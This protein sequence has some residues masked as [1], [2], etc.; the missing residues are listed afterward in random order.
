MKSLPLFFK[1]FKYLR[2][3]WIREIMLLLLMVIT[4][5]CSLASPYILKIIIDKVFP[6]G[7]FQ[8]LINI[9]AILV[10][11]NIMRI[12]ISFWSDYLY[13]W[14]SNHIVLDLRKDLFD[15][16]IHLPMS[17]FDK[18]KTGDLIHRINNEV[19]S[20][21]NMITGS[22]VRFINNFFTILGLTIALCLL[23]WKL[24]AISMVVVPFVFINTRYFQPKIHKIIKKA[25]E[26]DSD[27][28]N[29]FVERF[30]N[31]KLI[32]SY[33]RYNY[34]NHKLVSN[35]KELIGFNIINTKLS[36]G[37]SSIST[38]LVTLSPILIFVWGGKEVMLGAM[39]LG[40]LVAF[41][42]YL[43][44][45][46][47]PMRDIMSLYWDLVR[48]SVSMQRIF[49]FME[50]PVEEVS[51]EQLK[52]KSGKGNLYSVIGNRY[53]VGN[54][55]MESWEQKSKAKSHRLIADSSFKIGKCIRFEN[56]H[57][58]Y[59]DHWILNDLNLEFEKGKKYA[60]VGSSGCGK[61]TI[62]NL[63]NRFYEPQEGKILVDNNLVQ[64]FNLH[65]LRRRIAL[66]TQDN[67]L[68]HESIWENI[69]YGDF[70]SSDEQITDAAKLTNIYDHATSLKEGFSSKIG[71]K[72]TKI[73]GG[74]KQRIAIA[75]AML[76]R[77]ELI[78]LD[79]ATSALD[80]ESE[81]Q[82][83]L[84]LSNMYKDKT[85]IMISHRLS[86]IKDVDEIIYMDKGQVVEQGSYSELTGKK[87]LFWKLFKGQ[88]E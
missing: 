3:Y 73:S 45:L 35:I 7:D 10:G 20:I 24:F 64:S 42:Q 70:E 9:L 12:T 27:I 47:N 80:S 82:I 46:F 28:L 29:Y 13:V 16:L 65:E 44:R 14:V 60:I 19:N 2:P 26:K 39:T 31:I 74:Q 69:K 40:S 38:F 4:S 21:Q 58:K 62:I 75:R 57:F 15:H 77:A 43:N 68:F 83:Y 5:A 32:K 66:V 61:S 6:S 22:F 49:E 88:V 33:N 72:G 81:K 51:G 18:N 1:F 41:I 76:K 85:M 59:D 37:T 34:E 11:I 78:I 79:E 52:V 23:N 36:S 87:G 50:E 25:R 17:F 54:K 8:Y 30:E 48:S 55:K 84:N 63:V 71:D 53:S 67:Q 86:T 56:V